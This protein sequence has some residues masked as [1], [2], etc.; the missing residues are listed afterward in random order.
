[1]KRLR[2]LEFLVFKRGG[3]A[4]AIKRLVNRWNGLFSS[5]G[6]REALAR[7]YPL[8]EPAPFQI[9]DTLEWMERRNKI[10]CAMVNAW[11]KLYR[12]A[13]QQLWFKFT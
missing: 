11:E 12:R 5:S 1:M 9:Q 6:L 2:Q 4:G 8:L 13:P 3:V 10:I 7:K